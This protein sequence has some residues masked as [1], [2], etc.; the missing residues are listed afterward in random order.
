[1]DGTSPNKRLRDDSSSSPAVREHDPSVVSDVGGLAPGFGD[2]LEARFRQLEEFA[3]E[4]ARRAAEAEKK[5]ERMR[6]E[7]LATQSQLL[8]ATRHKEVI[9]QAAAAAAKAQRTAE[10]A[11]SRSSHLESTLRPSG[12]YSGPSVPAVDFRALAQLSA[13]AALTSKPEPFTGSGASV[14]MAAANWLRNTEYV[15][16][17]NEQLLQTA[18]TPAAEASRVALAVQAL[19]D[20]ARVWYTGL[21]EQNREPATWEEFKK[22]FKARFDSI[23]NAWLVKRQL[24]ELVEAHDGK[25]NMSMDKLAGILRSSSTSPT[26]WTIPSCPATLSWSLWP[27]ASRSAPARL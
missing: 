6:A 1:M 20:E 22:L 24:E 2:Q 17:T 12:P 16:R 7:L 21:T 14:G 27:E 23:N 11:A 18:N 5:A 8:E 4:S 19:K 3:H 25:G 10:E 13:Q 9:S 26:G 15:F